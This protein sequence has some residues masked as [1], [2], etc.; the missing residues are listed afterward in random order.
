MNQD[1]K[2][3]HALL[4]R[5]TAG[6]IEFTPEIDNR[7]YQEMSLEECW[8]KQGIKKVEKN[9]KLFQ[10]K[11]SPVFLQLVFYCDQLNQDHYS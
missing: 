4:R 11:F 8:Q 6:I 10:N 7:L 9:L 1:Q 5:F 2:S 3:K